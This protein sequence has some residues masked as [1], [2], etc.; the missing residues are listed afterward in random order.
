MAAL[1]ASRNEAAWEA[2]GDVQLRMSDGHTLKTVVVRD[3]PK[4]LK[5]VG[6]EN[7]FARP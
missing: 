1:W 2:K 5:I 7:C 4:L 6:D 3:L